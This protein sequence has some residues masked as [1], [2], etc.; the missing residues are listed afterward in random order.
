MFARTL[1]FLT[2]TTLFAATHPNLSLRKRLHVNPLITDPGT[3]ELDWGGA[4]PID[5][6]WSLP[7]AVRFAPAWGRTEFSA[8]FDARRFDRATFAATLV[9]LDTDH[10][11]VAVAPLALT[12]LR[13]ER[14]VRGGG[15]AIARYDG[16]SNSGGVTAAWVAGTV[17]LGAGYGRVFR[18]QVTAHVNG[19]WE[20]ATG[21]ARQ[22]TLLEGVEYQ[23]T[24]PLAVDVSA[25]HQ[26]LWGG[27][28]DH[29][30]IVGVT[31]RTPRLHR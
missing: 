6:P 8:T 22:I 10:F 11:D 17:D 3:F 14:G 23:I 4:F 24:D 15:A 30:I 1:V 29:Q 27:H 2:A 5:G 9:P 20:K 12:T 19:Q 31:F 25:Q 21:T 7:S 26:N 28:I 13:G 16:D 18:K